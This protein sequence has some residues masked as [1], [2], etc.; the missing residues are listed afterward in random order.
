[1]L[2]GLRLICGDVR[3]HAS[4]IEPR[5]NG[6]DVFVEGPRSLV[7][8]RQPP[9]A[10][11]VELRESSGRDDDRRNGS[12]TRTKPLQGLPH[13]DALTA[14]GLG[15]PSPH[16]LELFVRDGHD[17]L[18]ALDPYRHR[19]T[20]FEVRGVLEHDGS[21]GDSS[22]V[23]AHDTSIA[24]GGAQRDPHEG[25][26]PLRAISRLCWPMERGGSLCGEHGWVA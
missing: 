20:L 17:L 4:Q 3:S 23:Q 22:C 25:T 18:R 26:G 14:R 8:V 16:Q 2:L 5:D 7:A 13:V 15:L 21:L 10:S 9:L 19:R 6:I 11:L 24:R 1:V 12:P